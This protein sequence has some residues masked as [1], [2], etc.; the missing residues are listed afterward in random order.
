MEASA[1]RASLPGGRGQGRNASFQVSS[2]C[3]RT[4]AHP[5]W[6]ACGQWPVAPVEVVGTWRW[7]GLRC[8]GCYISRR[9]RSAQQAISAEK[10]VQGARRR[11]VTD[12]QIGNLSHVARHFVRHAQTLSVHAQRDRSADH[13][14]PAVHHCTVPTLSSLAAVS[15]A[16]SS[17]K[18]SC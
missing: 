18:L 5:S 13:R 7:P 8:Q 6:E 14:H 10:M 11:D 17:T 12:L 9:P 15:A 3:R 16:V 2:G 1:Q 4:T